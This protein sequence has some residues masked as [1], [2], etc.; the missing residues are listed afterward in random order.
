MQCLIYLETLDFALSSNTEQADVTFIPDTDE[1]LT[2]WRKRWMKSVNGCT[3]DIRTAELRGFTI[4]RRKKWE[5]SD[6]QEN[7]GGVRT[8]VTHWM[9]GVDEL[10]HKEG[11]LLR[12]LTE[13]K[14]KTAYSLSELLSDSW[15]SFCGWTFSLLTAALSRLLGNKFSRF[16][17]WG[18]KNRSILDCE[19]LS[20][21]LFRIGKR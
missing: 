8:V 6:S 21:Y 7:F 3:N 18:S 2:Q 15:A 4:R 1:E 13:N 20:S 9:D 19:V 16:W 5:L 17:G 10:L 14:Q 11:F 12:N